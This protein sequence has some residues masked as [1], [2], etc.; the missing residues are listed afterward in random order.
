MSPAPTRTSVPGLGPLPRP[1]LPPL[2]PP[3]SVPPPPPDPTHSSGLECP[4]LCLLR[5]PVVPQPQCNVG[6]DP[7]P[8]ASLWGTEDQPRPSAPTGSGEGPFPA[9][10]FLL[11]TTGAT[12]VPC[13]LPAPP[14]LQREFWKITNPDQMQP[15]QILRVQFLKSPQLPPSSFRPGVASGQHSLFVKMENWAS[16]SPRGGLHTPFA[17]I[18]GERMCGSGGLGLLL[19]GE[20]PHSTQPRLPCESGK[21]SPG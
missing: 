8:T 7:T 16:P 17:W 2:P 10:T 12:W 3:L 4:T 19:G 18:T 6:G 14:V 1:R 20:T 11:L 15:P 13:Q 9:W 21:S 5:G